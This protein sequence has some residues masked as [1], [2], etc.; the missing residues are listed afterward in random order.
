MDR[1]KREDVCNVFS[2]D[3]LSITVLLLPI[4]KLFGP[5]ART[6]NLLPASE[7]CFLSVSILISNGGTEDHILV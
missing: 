7:V 3:P 4:R 6:S 2:R 1:I 5:L